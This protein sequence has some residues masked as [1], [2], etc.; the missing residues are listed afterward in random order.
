MSNEHHPQ[1]PPPDPAEK[2]HLRKWLIIGLSSLIF[3]LFVAGGVP[4]W[5][6][7]EKIED[8]AN[9]VFTPKV[10]VLEAKRE[11]KAVDL[12]LPSTTQA[13][14]E[15]PI[16]AR[17]NGYLLKFNNDIGDHVKEGD[18]LAVL[19][20]PEVDQQYMQ[21]VAE[22]ATTKANRE[23]A[24]ISSERWQQL[25]EQNPEAISKQEVDERKA[26]YISSEAQVLSSEANVF[27]LKQLQ[28]FKYVTAPFDGIITARNI[29][30]GS[31]VT[32]G[33]TD[34][35]QWLFRIAQVD[36][37]RNFVNV[38]QNFYLG[39]KDGVEASVKIR[40]FPN[41]IFKGIVKRYAKALDPNARTLLTQVDIDN[42]SGE[43]YPG[44]YT[45]I[46]FHIKPDV[47]YFIIPT[48]AVI[49]RS[50]DPK[51]AVVGPNN[52]IELH[53]VQLGR[54]YGKTIEVVTGISPGDKVVTNPSDQIRDGVTVQIIE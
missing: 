44:I 1:I 42:K 54:D 6:H 47:P 7:F 52:K 5:F 28:D 38:P 51:L 17:T 33:S 16:W 49:I 45:E 48:A 26:T 34:N 20:T 30:I 27:R 35:T 3:L 36:F 32:S 23:I 15:T 22:L 50:G 25:Y 8:D 2:A 19:D 31:L 46:T 41:R 24:K 43:V 9:E 12:V 10:R 14:H 29:D 37:I 13:H 11:D 4:R 53:T 18:I 40:E 39:I 21:A